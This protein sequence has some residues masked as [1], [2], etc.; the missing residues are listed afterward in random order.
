MLSPLRKQADFFKI[1]PVLTEQ[2]RN[3]MNSRFKSISRIRRMIPSELYFGAT[4]ITF[5]DIFQVI[6]VKICC[7]G[8]Y[9]VLLLSALC[10]QCGCRK[11]PGFFSASMY[12]RVYIHGKIASN[13]LCEARGVQPFPD[14]KSLCEQ[15]FR[16]ILTWKLP[17]KPLRKNKCIKWGSLYSHF[18]MHPMC[19]YILL[20]KFIMMFPPP[21]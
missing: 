17:C 4:N 1:A 5:L 14:S 16:K 12:F 8:K 11:I 19:W 13:G 15:P 9:L 18:W 2:M 3:A 21:I 6:A 10:R 7:Q 20:T